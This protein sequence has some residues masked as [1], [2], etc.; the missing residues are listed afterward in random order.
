MRSINDMI[1][2]NVVLALYLNVKIKLV[3]VY[4]QSRRQYEDRLIDKKTTRDGW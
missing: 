1:T 3:D 4:F 2:I